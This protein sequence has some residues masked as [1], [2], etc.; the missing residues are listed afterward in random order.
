MPAR[1]GGGSSA[2]PSGLGLGRWRRA[3]LQ[4]H[5]LVDLPGLALRGDGEQLA[6]DVHERA[7]I[8]LGMV[9][10]AS[11]QL[12]PPPYQWRAFVLKFSSAYFFS[13]DAGLT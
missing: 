4:E 5:L 7:R 12:G 2:L 6:G 1:R 8:A 13:N 9:A 10:Q 11:D 3:G